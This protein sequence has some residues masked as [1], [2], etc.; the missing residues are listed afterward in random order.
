MV[1]VCKTTSKARVCD[2]D[3]L[4][5]DHRALYDLLGCKA[6]FAVLARILPDA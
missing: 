1:L 4:T 5:K 6:N 3:V 2:A